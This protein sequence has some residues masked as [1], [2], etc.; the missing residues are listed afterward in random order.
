VAQQLGAPA[1]ALHKDT[2]D[3]QADAA[4]EDGENTTQD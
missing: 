2:V 1:E 3:G 4:T